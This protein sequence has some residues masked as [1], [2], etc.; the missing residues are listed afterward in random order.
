MTGDSVY[1]LLYHRKKNLNRLSTEKAEV[2]KKA[3][4]SIVVSK[5]FSSCL[6]MGFGNVLWREAKFS[7]INPM[8]TLIHTH[9]CVGTDIDACWADN[10]HSWAPF[11]CIYEI[12]FLYLSPGC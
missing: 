6:A 7:A 4:V 5:S 9:E 12:Y 10:G 8:S 1:V 3:I 11:K 2:Q